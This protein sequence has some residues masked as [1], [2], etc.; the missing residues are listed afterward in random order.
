MVRSP[1]KTRCCMK[2]RHADGKF[3]IKVTDDDRCWTYSTDQRQMVNRI[4]MLNGLLLRLMAASPEEPPDIEK[5]EGRMKIET[6]V[7]RQRREE[8]L[9]REREEQT[10]GST[11][12][13]R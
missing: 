10:T 11:K 8:V 13:K 1:N 4:N 7:F 5:T 2:Y 12:K 3:L 6:E 9:K